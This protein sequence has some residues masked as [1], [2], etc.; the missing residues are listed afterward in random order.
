[1]VRFADAQ[2]EDWSWFEDMLAYDN[3]R[4]PQALIVTGLTTGTSA[5][6]E[7]GLKSLRWLVSVQ[8]S[9]EGYFRPVGTESFGTARS[10]PVAFDQQPIEAAATISACLAARRAEDSAEWATEARRAFGWFL[11]ENDLKTRLVDLITGSCC[12]GLHPDRANENRGAESAISYLVGLT[13]IRSLERDAELIR[14]KDASTPTNGAALRA[15]ALRA[16]PEKKLV[17]VA[18]LESPGSLLAPGS[19]QSRRQTVQAGDRTERPEP[20]R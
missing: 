13:E 6:V 3:A 8:T 20:D 10:I 12:D 14:H 16:I 1:M 7:T 11:G 19:S 17:S 2:T 5:Y 9:R 15:V 4:L 18:I